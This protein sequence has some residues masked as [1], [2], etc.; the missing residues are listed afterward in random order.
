MDYDSGVKL[1]CY[2]NSAEHNRVNKTNFL[3]QVD[4]IYCYFKDEVNLINPTITIE[5]SVLPTFN[6]IYIEP[7]NRYYYVSNITS[8]RNN[9]WELELTIDILMSYKDA[10]KNLKGFIDRNENT[11]N[12][13]I[14]DNK[15]VFEQNYSKNKYTVS[16]D[17]FIDHF[18]VDYEFL[19]RCIVMTGYE[20][21]VVEIEIEE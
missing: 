21:S 6:Y 12:S 7:F 10:I 14:I 15:V 3:T 17:I 5:Y 9:V 4:E 13:N 20:L 1:I 18:D 2:E 11:F 8:I 16:N 19:S